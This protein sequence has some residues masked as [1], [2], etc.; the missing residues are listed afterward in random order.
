MPKDSNSAGGRDDSKRPRERGEERDPDQPESRAEALRRELR[1]LE[2]QGG[3]SSKKP[4]P[5]ESSGG[6]SGPGGG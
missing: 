6:A 1:E 5:S 3:P 4:R 2:N